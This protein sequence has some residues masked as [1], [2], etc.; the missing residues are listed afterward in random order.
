MHSGH[1]SRLKQKF[2]NGEHLEDHELLELAL[3]Y[4][5]PRCD[6]NATAH[7]LINRFGSLRGI[8][9][10]SEA[11]LCSVKGI[12]KSSATYIRVVAEII[13]RSKLD[14]C[15]TRRLLSSKAE[16]E[17]FLSALFFATPNEEVHALFFDKKNRYISEECI[18]TGDAIGSSV[19]LRKLLSLSKEKG[20]ACVI[21][22]H[23][24]T[25]GIPFP[26]TR[27]EDV[28]RT[29]AMAL[30]SNKIRLIEHYIVTN[31]RCY[32]IINA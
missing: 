31:D 12:G 32:P 29:I 6:T 8:F 30:E 25:N 13:M 17:C 14:A 10:A 23:N 4:V 2:K 16:L 22:A 26:S 7:L 5:I 28:T 3:Y 1:R 15:D 24:H 27:D 9:C 21:L 20:V 18:G 11:E 19:N